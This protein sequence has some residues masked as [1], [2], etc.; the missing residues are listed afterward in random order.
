MTLFNQYY[1]K[2]HDTKRSALMSNDFKWHIYTLERHV[3]LIIICILDQHKI[4][5]GNVILSF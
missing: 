5:F 4:N 3:S 2:L 1:F